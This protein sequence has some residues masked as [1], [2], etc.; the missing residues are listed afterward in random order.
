MRLS[1]DIWACERKMAGSV[2]REE[3][4][5]VQRMKGKRGHSRSARCSKARSR[6]WMKLSPSAD[7]SPVVEGKLVRAARPSHPH[8]HL[9]QG[10]WEMT[11]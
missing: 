5:H 6:P 3:A 4:G 2:V 1:L 9:A 8:I 10:G 7:C 11:R